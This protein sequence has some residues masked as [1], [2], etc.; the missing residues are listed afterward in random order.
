MPAYFFNL[1]NLKGPCF[2][3]QRYRTKLERNKI[4]RYVL[5]L[6]SPVRFR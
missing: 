4:Y 1:V 2:E 5:G 3:N 6:S